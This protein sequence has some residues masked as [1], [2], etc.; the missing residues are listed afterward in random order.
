MKKQIKILCVFCGAEELQIEDSEMNHDKSSITDFHRC[1]KCGKQ[2]LVTFTTQ[3]N[4]YQI[5]SRGGE[6][7]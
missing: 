7:K 5:E 3:N 1:K 4:I 2:T 6:P